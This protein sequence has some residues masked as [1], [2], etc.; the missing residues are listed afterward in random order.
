M[1]MLQHKI[2]KWETLGVGISLKKFFFLL[3]LNSGISYR[4][5]IN[6]NSLAFQRD[7]AFK[8]RTKNTEDNL[9]I[10]KLVSVPKIHYFTPLE[11]S[12]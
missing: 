6:Q 10:F 9:T 12:E 7:I 8:D 1:K 4:K 2:V 5:I 11:N 3:K